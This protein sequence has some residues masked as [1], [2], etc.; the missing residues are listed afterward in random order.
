MFVRLDPDQTQPW[1]RTKFDIPDLLGHVKEHRGEILAHV[2]TLVR[3]WIEQ[4]R[5]DAPRGTPELGSFTKW[6]KVVPAILG[7]ASIT[8]VLGDLEARAVEMRDPDE[9]EM[10]VFL[11]AW[12]SGF[13]FSQEGTTARELVDWSA[14]EENDLTLPSF[15]L[16]RNRENQD[17][18][19]KA[20]SLTRVLQ[21]RK[22][23]WYD[24]GDGVNYCVRTVGGSSKRGLKWRVERRD[25][26]E[27]D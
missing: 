1:L 20:R 3:Y 12:H 2:Y 19:S 18:A 14:S 5:P 27:E 13:P 23:R 16:G 11:E 21:Y 9:W 25:S 6:S 8:G 24:A 15:T 4:D 17:P 10:T 26:G 22:D 7:A